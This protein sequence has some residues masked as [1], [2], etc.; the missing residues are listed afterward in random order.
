MKIE[1]TLFPNT[2]LAINMAIY[3]IQGSFILRKKFQ[4]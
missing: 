3:G 4:R 2:S 1:G